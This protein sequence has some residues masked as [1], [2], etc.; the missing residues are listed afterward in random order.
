MV[1]ECGSRKLCEGPSTS[2]FR[3]VFLFLCVVFIGNEKT[4]FRARPF[5]LEP[6]CDIV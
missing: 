6:E 5:V 1:K 4:A 3:D 2:A